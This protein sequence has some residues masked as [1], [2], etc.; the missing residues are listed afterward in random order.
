MGPGWRAE[1]HHSGIEWQHIILVQQ[2]LCRHSVY[3]RTGQLE[4]RGRIRGWLVPH[5]SGRTERT[6][7]LSITVTIYKQRFCSLDSSRQLMGLSGAQDQNSH[8]ACVV[9][10]STCLHRKKR[11]NRNEVE[12]NRSLTYLKPT[13][14][15]KMNQT[16]II[17]NVTWDPHNALHY[18]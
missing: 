18:S 15:L 13:G 16:W 12:S 7:S 2:A 14:R 3:I 8:R 11:K 5:S 9:V 10:W 17:A 4:S 6:R 1:L